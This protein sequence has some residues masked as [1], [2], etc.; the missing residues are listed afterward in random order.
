[1]TK[2]GRIPCITPT[3]KRTTTT[4]R[5]IYRWNRQGRKGQVCTVT[6]RGKMN[7][8]CMKYKDGYT[9][10]EPSGFPI[11]FSDPK[12]SSRRN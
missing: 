5:Y 3:C 11:V 7:S 1:M 4:Q 12:S 8:I 2:P 10:H 6:A 9:S